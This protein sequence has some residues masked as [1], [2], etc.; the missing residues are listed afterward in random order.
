MER[1]LETMRRC[2]VLVF[3]F[4]VAFSGCKT[5]QTSQ[6]STSERRPLMNGKYLTGWDTY[7]GALFDSLGKHV[8]DPIGV[9][10][11]PKKT[12]TIVREDNKP[13]LRISGEQFGGIS[14]QNEFAN[15]HLRLEFK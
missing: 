12:F 9:N 13:A 6:T 14:T 10:T 2:V 15:F 1:N 8:G 4:F 11:D 3:I 5:A 7:F